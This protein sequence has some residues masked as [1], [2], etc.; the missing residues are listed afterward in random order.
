M[1]VTALQAANVRA[2]LRLVSELRELG[3]PSAWRR[4]LSRALEVLCGA[5]V[6]LVGELGMSDARGSESRKGTARQPPKLTVLHRDLRGIA[7]TDVSRFEHDVA[8]GIHG[9]NDVFSDHWSRYGQCF[10]AARRQ[11]AEDHAW[12]RSELANERFRAF[13]CDDFI[14]HMLPVPSLNALTSIKMFRAWG[15]RPFGAQDRLLI[16]LLGEE[17][18]HDW[19]SSL[20]ARAARAALS[21]RQQQVLAL[22]VRG[23]SDKDVAAALSISVHTAHGYAKALYRSCQVHSRAELITRLAPGNGH[24][25]QLVAES[26]ALSEPAFASPPADERRD[27]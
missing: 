4:H 1:A 10:T 24:R 20:A 18:A 8:W 25:A 11:L 14:L 13:D 3:A 23:A 26:L 6:V 5:R 27:D 9:P 17:L 12:Y 16:E 15:D 22:L 2:L 19:N 7:S 21:P